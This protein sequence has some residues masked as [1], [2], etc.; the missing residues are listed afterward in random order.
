MKTV[1]LTIDGRTVQVDEGAT[2]LDAA[3]KAG[4]RIPTLC[5]HPQLKPYGACRLCMVEIQKGSRRRLVA[6]CVY[7]AEEGLAVDTN[8][9]KVRKIRRMIIELLWPASQTFAKE[10][11]V[12]SSRFPPQNTDCHLCGLCVRYCSE[13][14][15]ADVIFLK[16]R[17]IDRRP[18]FLPGIDGKCDECRQCYELCTGG[19]VV[20]HRGEASLT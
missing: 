2:L 7:L 4:V 1:S 20:T 18:A 16:G 13:V 12:E 10:Y 9:E 6:S 11:G 17:G 15:K 5:H 3:Q 8:T 19:W 14:K